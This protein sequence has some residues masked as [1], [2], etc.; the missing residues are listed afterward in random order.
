V[1][2]PGIKM[3]SRNQMNLVESPSTPLECPRCTLLSPAG[4][5]RCDCGYRFTDGVAPQQKPLDEGTKGVVR[6]WLVRR[7]VIGNLAAVLGAWF[8]FFS[9]DQPVRTAWIIALIVLPAGNAFTWYSWRYYPER[10]IRR[11]RPWQRPSRQTWLIVLSI[12]NLVI[13]WGASIFLKRHSHGDQT[14]MAVETIGAVALVGL[15]ILIN[16]EDSRFR[17]RWQVS[18]GT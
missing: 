3:F 8:I 6:R 4:T 13:L 18:T 9:L 11:L 5:L 10:L 16:R 1:R 15:E 2:R 12:V 7:T 17:E 14:G